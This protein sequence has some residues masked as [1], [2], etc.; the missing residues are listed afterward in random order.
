M[1]KNSLTAQKATGPIRNQAI[2]L[3]KLILSVFVVLIHAEVEIGIFNPFLRMAVPLFFMTSGYYFFQK[4]GS[5]KSIKE[6]TPILAQFLK[7]NM[8]LYGFWF[9]VLLPITLYIRDWF[10]GSFVAGLLHMLQ[11]FLFNSTFRA[12]W[13]IMALNIGMCIVF[14]ASRKMKPGQ[15]VCLCFPA[16]LLCCLFTNYYELMAANETIMK[17]Y[18]G[19]ISVFASLC[20]SFP[21]SLFWLA[22]GNYLAS[23]EIQWKKHALGILICLATVGLVLEYLLVSNLSLQLADDA[24]LMLT[25]L[26]F[27]VFCFVR[28]VKWETAKPQN[29]GK[30]STIIYA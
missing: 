12:S 8:K 28:N 9:V 6:A 5:D 26:C 13:Y 20:N 15:L 4:V 22:L 23:R 14:A 24:Y 18:Q 21:A 11:D 19:Y 3:M 16:Y 29:W 1:E 27:G 17:C 10:S 25:P 30:I 2:D 7:R